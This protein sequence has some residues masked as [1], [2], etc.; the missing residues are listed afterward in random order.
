MSARDE[1]EV[2]EAFA[3]LRVLE[4]R[5]ELL[6]RIAAPRTLEDAVAPPPAP[7]GPAAYCARCARSGVGAC[8]D[9]PDCPGGRP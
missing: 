1:A 5:L 9:F 2:R 4:D 6:R 8:D 3:E 7:A